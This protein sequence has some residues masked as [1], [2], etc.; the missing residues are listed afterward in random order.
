MR[1][2]K[3][4]I[5]FIWQSSYHDHIIRNERAYD[6]IKQYIQ[7]NPQKWTEDSIYS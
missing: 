6:N 3:Q 5:P 7:N 2:R 1:Y 4:C